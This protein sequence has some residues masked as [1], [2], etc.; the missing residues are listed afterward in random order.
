MA[1]G[2]GHRDTHNPDDLRQ[3]NKA[4]EELSLAHGKVAEL[5]SEL[6]IKD[7]ALDELAARKA[8][9]MAAQMTRERLEA[10]LE[11]LRAQEREKARKE[12][13][14]ERERTGRELEEKLHALETDREAL[15]KDREKVDE[16]KRKVAEDM[17]KLQEEKDRIKEAVLKE[18]DKRIAEAEAKFEARVSDAVAKASATTDAKLV[19]ALGITKDLVTKANLSPEE[20]MGL[21]GKLDKVGKEL[22]ETVSAELLKT[23]KDEDTKGRKRIKAIRRY[24]RMLFGTKSEKCRVPDEELDALLTEILESDVLKVTD[25]ERQRAKE[26]QQYCREIRA[27]EKLWEIVEGKEPKKR[28]STKEKLPDNLPLYGGKPIVVYP[29]EYNQNP[30]DYIEVKVSEGTDDRYGTPGR[31]KT[32]ELVPTDTPFM[33]RVT[34]YP[35]VVR[36]RDPDGTP[37]QAKRLPRPIDRGYSSPEILAQIETNKFDDH[38]PLYR[39]EEMFK[40][41]GMDF[42]T[43]QLMDC[44]HRQVSILLDPLYDLMITDIMTRSNTLC[45]D[46]VPT[47]VV[48]TDAHK[49]IKYYVAVIVSPTL[50]MEL[51][52]V[53]RRKD[54]NDPTKYAGHGR[55]QEDIR[56]ALEQWT[57]QEGK[58]ACLHDGYTGWDEPVKEKGGTNCLCNAHARRL[59]DE[60]FPESPKE[61]KTG[62]AFYKVLS[63]MERDIEEQHYTNTRKTEERRK[64]RPF[65]KS[66]LAWAA[67]IVLTA[68]PNSSIYDAAKYLLDHKEGLMAY[69]NNPE[70]PFTNNLPDRA[71]KDVLMGRR[72]SR[73][74]KSV[75][76]AYDA[77]KFYTFIGT[78]KMQ[79]LNPCTWLT[80]A[81][82]NIKRIP[83]EELWRALPQY[84]NQ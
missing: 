2:F 59:F 39:Q 66:F 47:N 30:D 24:T 74:F 68:D 82:A 41:M 17:D 77:C 76:S 48:S 63:D 54:E 27:K 28:K 23:L 44:W 21:Y 8:E 81:L 22:S 84:W 18:A 70:V 75:D 15:R 19:E 78:A 65:W 7:A 46:G 9:E 80:Y 3:L 20:R 38:M 45:G 10:M 50:H 69:L 43:R 53:S 55:Y 37:I 67:N 35:K 34:E 1:S 25:K 42:I 56:L 58:G 64:E 12:L 62:I 16:A 36:K 32:L 61:A 13:E 71:V 26:A 83:K 52:W 11:E 60:S 40:R 14:E 6:I 79:G 29:E 31:E 72:S 49:C 51:Y 5:E 4:L 73:F 57:P 33:V